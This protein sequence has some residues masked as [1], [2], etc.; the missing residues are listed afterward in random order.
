[1]KRLALVLAFAA[2]SES[3]TAV[4][5]PPEAGAEAGLDARADAPGDAEAGAPVSIP[6]FMPSAT[7]FVDG[8]L[9][10]DVYD[11][12]RGA[13]YCRH[14]ENTDM[15]VWNGAIW[16]VHRTAISQ[17]LGP[18][19]ALRVY[20]SVDH[21]QSFQQTAIIPAPTDR[22]I[23]DPAF[24][25]VGDKLY[26]KVLE[27]LPPSNSS[28]GARDSSVDTLSVVKT[29]SD[30]VTWTDGQ[31]VAP[32]GWSFWRVKENAGV[33][34]SAAYQDGDLQV[35]MYTSH[36]GLTW[37]A[38]PQVYG[39]AADT[40]LETELTF[41]PSGRL[42]ALVRT[43]GT[44]AEL[45]GDQGRLRTQL[46]WAE[47]PSYAKFSCTSEFDG[48]RLDGPVS[49][50]WQSRLFVV[51]RK[52]LQGTGKKRT[53]LFEILNFEQAAG[54]DAGA[55]TIQEWGEL[56]SAGDTS[57]AGVAMTDSTHAVVSWYS[58]DLQADRPWVLAM[59][60]LTSIWLGT[61]DFSRL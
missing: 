55:P 42:L 18:N 17:A 2:C 3:G 1:M 37:T 34:Y 50:F 48:Q 9:Y 38:G 12:C 39:V 8:H 30:G 58:G 44:D 25:A 59:F 20:K 61:I 36:D 43:D 4:A 15:I 57:Y 56:P 54:Q 22:D 24:F 60:D 23:R 10:D 14:N 6:A 21:G 26:L 40:P 51:A 31:V 27:R 7:V 49:F 5:P 45:L 53:S 16:L 35:V 52:H 46:C 41:M 11:K 33:Y 13:T 47:P 19:S 28:S 29:S 32:H